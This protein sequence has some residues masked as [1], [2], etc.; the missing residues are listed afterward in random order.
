MGGGGLTETAFERGLGGTIIRYADRDYT[1]AQWQV[2]RRG[3]GLTDLGAPNVS[4]DDIE[5]R[6]VMG[7]DEDNFWVIDDKAVVFQL[8]EGTWRY[9]CTLPGRYSRGTIRGAV[10][11]EDML[12]LAGQT[13]DKPVAH[14]V[15]SASGGLRSLTLDDEGKAASQ[16]LPI[17]RDASVI[18]FSSDIFFIAAGSYYTGSSHKVTDGTV[19]VLE[20]LKGHQESV[21]VD[22]DGNA[23][24]LS[25]SVGRQPY[26]ALQHMWISSSF[27]EADVAG[28]AR[29]DQ[30]YHQHDDP[31]L[32][33]YR[34]GTWAR[35]EDVAL[36]EA[37]AYRTGWLSRDEQGQHFAV[38]IG[39]G[40]A[41]VYRQ[42]RGVTVYPLNVATGVTDGDLIDVWGTGP[43]KFWTMSRTGSVWEWSQGRW[44]QVI[45]GLG[46][47]NTVFNDAWGS[48]DGTVFAVTDDTLYKLDQVES[49]SP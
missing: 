8:E 24:K 25:R 34:D 13:R 43:D 20:P 19:E 37:S 7:Y 18:P 41:A 12:L 39:P 44:R 28:I 9:L 48:P 10:L 38:F 22:R 31:M 40:R 45:N 21:I 16:A 46:D 33:K 26:P 5:L 49:P 30:G 42:G 36:T 6:R 35:I 15:D 1:D 27:A 17:P 4:R 32:V 14:L 2:V 47:E 29:F 11:S 23:L 3:A